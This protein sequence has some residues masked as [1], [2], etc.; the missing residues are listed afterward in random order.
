MPGAGLLPLRAA[1]WINLAVFSFYTVL[2]W[3]RGRLSPQRRAKITAIGVSALII[4][5]FV[6]LVVPHLVTPLAASVIRD[7]VPYLLLLLLYWQGGQFVTHANVALEDRLERMD[8]KM[9]APLLEWFARAPLG[10]WILGYLEGS[11][12]F[13]YASMPLGLGTLYMLR[14]GR[15][16][17]HYWTVVLL[18]AYASYGMLP[19]IQLRPPRMLGE[20]W[21]EPLLAG[22]VRS[23]NLWILRHASIHA[24]TFPSG[25]VAAATACAFILLRVA[26]LWVGLVF[27]FL[28]INIAL[29]AVIG[30]YHYLADAILGVLVAAVGF[31][32][33]KVVVAITLITR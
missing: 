10:G 15:E 17:D 26:P 25:H 8:R 22:K 23:L 6:S 32:A 2:G 5:L 7:W 12:L 20:K 9:V 31:L 28:A 4:T 24:N 14:R 33:D 18:A 19:F 27:L 1:E 16:A 21:S 3:R 30:R 29:A 11:Y 13:C